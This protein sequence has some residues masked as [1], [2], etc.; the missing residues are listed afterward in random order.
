M[1]DD[2]IMMVKTAHFCIDLWTKLNVER[3]GSSRILHWLTDCALVNL[4]IV[5]SGING[6]EEAQTKPELFRP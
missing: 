2:A 1:A 4:G 3:T 5:R 6:K